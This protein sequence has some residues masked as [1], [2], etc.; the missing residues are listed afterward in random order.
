MCSLYAPDAHTEL[1]MGQLEKLS[2]VLILT[3]LHQ[4]ELRNALR[5]RVF[6]KE[7][8]PDQ[9]KQS[10]RMFESDIVDG[11]YLRVHLQPE[12]VERE[13]ERLSELYAEKTGTRSLDI[14][15]VA[16]ANL[17][18]TGPFYGFDKRQNEL[19]HASGLDVMADGVQNSI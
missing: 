18:S 4:V 10:I 5:L 17:S 6:R 15:H 14:L 13:A 16:M 9:R 8:T 1:V 11:L 12:D 3:W 2:G 7:I 19:A